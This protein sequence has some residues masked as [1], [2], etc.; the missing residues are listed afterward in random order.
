MSLC[1]KDVTDKY[2]SYY[3]FPKYIGVELNPV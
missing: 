1:N 3:L 2:D